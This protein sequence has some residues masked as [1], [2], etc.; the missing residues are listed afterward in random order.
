MGIEDFL[1]A[2][3]FG[4]VV[5]AT[6][7]QSHDPV[8]DR[9]LG[10]EEESGYLGRERADPSQQLDAVE[11]RQHHIKDQDVGTEV[12]GQFHCFR[13]VGRHRH[14][15]AGHAQAHAHQLRKAW[16]VVDHQGADGGAVGVGK[17]GEVVGHGV[18]SGH[19]TTL[20]SVV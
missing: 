17:L 13:A 9:V 11:P 2:E 1:H 8:L 3:R 19:G 20:R 5:V 12:L 6:G 4:D 10:S 16:L 14:R 15:P 7:R 18:R